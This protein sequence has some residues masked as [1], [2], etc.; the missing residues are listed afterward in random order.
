MN[1]DSLII[2]IKTMKWYLDRNNLNAVV[3]F[4]NLDLFDYFGIYDLESL[5]LKIEDNLKHI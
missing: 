4:S 2:K 3:T 5:N 1:P